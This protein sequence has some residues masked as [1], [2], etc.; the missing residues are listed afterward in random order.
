[1]I[2]LFLAV[3]MGSWAQENEGKRP[4]YCEVM[5]MFNAVSKM[6]VQIDIGEFNYINGFAG[7][8]EADGKKKKFKTMMDALNFMGERGW[9][10]VDTYIV[11]YS[12][13]NKIVHYLMEKWVTDES[14]IKEG[15]ILKAEKD[16]LEKTDYGDTY[17]IPK[18]KDAEDE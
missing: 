6:K 15:L 9:R 17:Y 14:Q 10:V 4:V 13:K 3:C 2:I 1:M 12:S 5:G 11:S 16:P 7:I 8:Y 18:K